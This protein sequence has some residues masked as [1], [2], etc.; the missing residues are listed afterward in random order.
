[1]IISIDARKLFEKNSTPIPDKNSQKTTRDWKVP[2]S[3]KGNL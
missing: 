1:M 3:D 2:Q